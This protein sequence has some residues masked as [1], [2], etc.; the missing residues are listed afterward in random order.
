MQKLIHHIK[1]SLKSYFTLEKR[2]K[3]GMFTFQWHITEKCNLRCTHCYQEGCDEMMSFEMM[4]KI[5][6]D[7][8]TFLVKL[9]KDRKLDVLKC[10]VTVTG[11]EPLSH[12]DFWKLAD[13]I[14]ADKNMLLSV[15]TN[16]TLITEKTAKRLAWLKPHYVQVSID[17]D[18]ATHD[19]I[20]GEGN[21]QKAVQGLKHLVTHG[22]RTSM[23]F[24]VHKENRE[25]FKKVVALGESIGVNQIWSD[26]LIPCGSGAS[27][28]MLTPQETKEYFEEMMELRRELISRG[29]KTQVTLA[30]AL[31]FLAG[32]LPYKCNAGNMLLALLPNGD[33]LPCRRMAIN[34]GNIFKESIKVCYDK[35]PAALRRINV[36]CNCEHDEK[37][38]GGLRCLAYAVNNDPFTADPGCWL[39]K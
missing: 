7:L 27:L 33:I 12:P 8:R 20:R 39:K 24:T 14:L 1:K 4:E 6:A 9:K 35:F 37:C 2:R 30:R 36:K 17:G 29:S 21:Y 22:V 26:R 13:S 28:E 32:G 10:N 5:L 11:G 3:V 16:G 31:Q 38:N 19:N 34:S 25:Q 18:E 15:L 23:S